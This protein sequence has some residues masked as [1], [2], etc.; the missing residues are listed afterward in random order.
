MI[1]FSLKIDAERFFKKLDTTA[2]KIIPYAIVSLQRFAEMARDKLRQTTP[3]SSHDGG[4]HLAD[5]WVF[6][7]TLSGTITQYEIFNLTPDQDILAMLEEGTQPHW[8]FPKDPEG[9]LH[10]VD[11][12][13]GKDF[14]AKNVAHPGTKAYKMVENVRIEMQQTLDT[15]MQVTLDTALGQLRSI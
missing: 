15:Y 1:N 14:Y 10:W 13:S 8:I 11:E 3:K 4:I 5:L 2:E 9:V 6:E 7:R 12:A